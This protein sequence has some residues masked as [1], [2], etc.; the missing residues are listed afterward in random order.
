MYVDPRGPRVV[1]TITTDRAGYR[2]RDVD[3]AGSSPRRA[4]VFGIAAIFGVQASPY[5]SFFKRVIRPRLDPPTELEPAG[6]PRFAQAVGFGF[7]ILGAVGY[8]TGVTPL[9][10]V[11]TAFATAG[12]V[13]QRGLRLLPGLRGPAADREAAGPPGRLPGPG[14]TPRCSPP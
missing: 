12:R 2:A 9:G 3:R 6:P 14:Q 11:A 10:V 5:S 7:A 13:P 8:L 4:V 1:A